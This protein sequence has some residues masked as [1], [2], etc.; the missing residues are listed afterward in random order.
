[1]KTNVK[2]T[3]ADTAS[4]RGG[5]SIRNSI[6]HISAVAPSALNYCHFPLSRRLIFLA[7]MEARSAW[8]KLTRDSNA[9]RQERLSWA[10]WLGS[11]STGRWKKHPKRTSASTALRNCGGES[12]HFMTTGSVA[13]IS[14]PQNLCFHP[15]RV[16]LLHVTLLRQNSWQDLW[17]G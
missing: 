2:L 10:T 8:F 17:K 3:P 11:Y 6:W 5:L 1:M 16:S 13:I 14:R 9:R 4:E 15:E 7:D 12:V